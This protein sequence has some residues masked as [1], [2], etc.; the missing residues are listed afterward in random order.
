MH[1]IKNDEN[2]FYFQQQQREAAAAAAAQAA[3]AAAAEAARKAAKPGAIIE[4]MHHL[5]QGV[6][7]GTF[8]GRFRGHVMRISLLYLMPFVVVQSTLFYPQN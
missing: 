2:L 5:G 6:Y 4:S 8:S 1:F 3:A 7:S